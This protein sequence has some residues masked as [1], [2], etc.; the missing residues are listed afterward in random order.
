MKKESIIFIIS[1]LLCISCGLSDAQQTASSSN[2]QDSVFVSIQENDSLCISRLVLKKKDD[3]TVLVKMYC[4]DGSSIDFVRDIHQGGRKERIAVY[5]IYNAAT[6][7]V[8]FLFFDYE[9]KMAY[10][11]PDSFSDYS[12]VYDSLNLEKRYVML[13]RGRSSTIRKTD[14]TVHSRRSENLH[15]KG[16][17][18]TVKVGLKV[19]KN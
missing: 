15:H 14:T 10:I 7:S 5:E 2:D 1:I 11:T 9:T 4:T 19:I 17:N 16:Q 6:D 3:E 18:L 12:P 13:E 8:R